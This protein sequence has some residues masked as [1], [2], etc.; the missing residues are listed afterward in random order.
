MRYI[1]GYTEPVVPTNQTIYKYFTENKDDI[2]ARVLKD[3]ETGE[4]LYKSAVTFFNFTGTAPSS[5]TADL[6]PKTPLEIF[7]WFNDSGITGAKS[8]MVKTHSN[9]A[10]SLMDFMGVPENMRSTLLH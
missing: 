1:E 8:Y 9:F 10:N 5:S 2:K 7:A 3:G 4:S 6:S